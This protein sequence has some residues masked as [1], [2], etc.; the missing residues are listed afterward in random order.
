MSQQHMLMVCLWVWHRRR[1]KITNRTLLASHV[2]IEIS[3]RLVVVIKHLTFLLSHR[4]V[5]LLTHKSHTK[6]E[7]SWSR[8]EK[9]HKTCHVSNHVG[10]NVHNKSLDNFSNGFSL[11]RLA[12]AATCAT[13]MSILRQTTHII[14]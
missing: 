6:E 4:I 13:L 5:E 1:W 10:M 9:K 8:T 14:E 7:R 2:K 12:R 11:S 3:I